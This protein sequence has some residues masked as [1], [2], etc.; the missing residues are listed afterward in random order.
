MA[1]SLRITNRK[2]RA[3]GW[4][5]KYRSVREGWAHAVVGEATHHGGI[6]PSEPHHA[7]R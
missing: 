5:P 4:E 6:F 1:R 2:L 3:S 7:A